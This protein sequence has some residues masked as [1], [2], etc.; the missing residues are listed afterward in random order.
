MDKGRKGQNGW[1]WVLLI[2]ST[3]AIYWLQAPLAPRFADTLLPTATLALAVLGWLLTRPPDAAARQT[4]WPEDRLTLFV[5]FALVVGMA[6]NRYL[7]GAYRLTASRPPSPWLTAVALLLLGGF[8]L[9]I[10]RLTDRADQRRVLTGSIVLVVGL[11]VVLKSAP[12]ATAAA[13][14]WRSLSGQNPSLAAPADL[15]WL[16]FSYVAFRLIHTLRDRQTG[17]LPHLSLREYVTYIIFA[18][19][20]IAGP[21]D[22]AERFV[23]DIRALPQ[24]VVLDAA[25]FGE[26]GLRIAAGLFKKLVI[27][28]SL[29]QGM[30]LTAVNAT[31]VTSPLAL[32]AL[33]YGYALRLYFDFAGYTDIAI[34]VGLLLG[35]RLPEN[36][37]RPYLQTNIT[38]FWQSWHMTLSSWA[39][40]YVFTPLSR[41]LL[42]RKPR[43]SP[44]LIVF[45][46]QIATMTTIGLW[47]GLTWTF[48]IWGLWHGVGLF[49][50]K[51][52][53]DRTRRWY[54]ALEGKPGQKRA[55]A[56]FG[57]F[58]TFHFVVVGW[59][60]F[61][62]P[63]VDQ[64]AATFAKLLGIG[65]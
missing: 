49:I 7:D 23:Q 40:F 18:P 37:N 51:Q 8:V 14:F 3:L 15:A 4:T 64:A 59:V 55:W 46:A 9:L 65:W 1:G 19:A 42:R 2:G 33:L 6:F 11:F 10:A 35:I 60:W 52:W 44:T 63:D 13:Q 26:A 57:W 29:A 28:D 12:L 24:L 21:I 58:I 54:R 32:W 22:R 5:L 38:T 20:F 43:P 62:L 39:R 53:S 25:R 48:L 31:Q 50:H 41:T 16:G 61:L 34:G 17:L 30:S 56:L 45:I 36:F 47:H 27:A